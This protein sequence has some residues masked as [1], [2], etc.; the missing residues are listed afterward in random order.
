MLT[1]YLQAW[2]CLLFCRVTIQL[3]LYEQTN[4][5]EF[6]IVRRKNPLQPSH[7]IALK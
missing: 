6:F 1:T 2:H 3:L 7:V 4:F 5:R